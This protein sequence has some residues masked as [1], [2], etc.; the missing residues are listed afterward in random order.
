M[1]KEEKKAINMLN[2]FRLEHKFFNI[3]QANN[4]E[5]NIEIV[6]NLLEELQEE[7]PYYISEELEEKGYT[8]GTTEIYAQYPNNETY[9]LKLGRKDE[10]K[11]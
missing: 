10:K 9:Y 5:T 3:I 2:T 4:L 7:N 11:L 6:L 1:T 8:S